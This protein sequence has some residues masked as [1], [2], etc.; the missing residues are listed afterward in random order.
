M[1]NIIILKMISFK[2]QTFH[3]LFIQNIYYNN[4]CLTL[5]AI[6]VQHHSRYARDYFEC[7]GKY[8]VHSQLILDKFTKKFKIKNIY[9][10]NDVYY[11]NV[12]TVIST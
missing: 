11:Y 6:T 9:L 10:N 7:F 12:N 5:F 2:F 3:T 8:V 4:F 1:F